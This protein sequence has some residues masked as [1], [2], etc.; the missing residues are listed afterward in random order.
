MSRRRLW[1]AGHLVDFDG[2]RALCDADA[3]FAP[4][5]GDKCEICLERD[6]FE[7]ATKAMRSRLRTVLQSL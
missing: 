2:Y 4:A 6:A 3:I 5:N 1:I 7:K